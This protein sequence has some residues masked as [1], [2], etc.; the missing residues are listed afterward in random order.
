MQLNRE[1]KRR[2]RRQGQLGPDGVPV[3]RAP[4]PPP[5]RDASERT[6]VRQFLREVRGELRKVVWPT[7][8]ET[9]NY[10]VVVLATLVF[11]TLLIFALDWVFARVILE[12]FET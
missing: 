9:V 8:E 2:L 6:S 11:F 7:R 1:A 10:S 12:L 3:R 4:T 5:R